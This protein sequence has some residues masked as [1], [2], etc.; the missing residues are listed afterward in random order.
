MHAPLNTRGP[1]PTTHRD[2]PVSDRRPR[3]IFIGVDHR[4]AP[5]SQCVVLE[6]GI[7]AGTV[8]VRIAAPSWMDVDTLAIHTDNGV[9][10]EIA[11]PPYEGDTVRLDTTLTLNFGASTF[12][13][14]VVRGDQNSPIY[15]PKTP[16]AVSPIVRFE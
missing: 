7:D 12:A 3:A 14:A 15:G 16:V 6:E 2:P 5:L 4:D 9:D 1:Q 11:V 10:Q 13:V 8:H